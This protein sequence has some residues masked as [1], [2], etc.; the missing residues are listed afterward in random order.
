MEKLSWE[1]AR[2]ITESYFLPFKC[3]V[4]EARSDYKNVVPFVV[5]YDFDNSE[6][7]YGPFELTKFKDPERLELMLSSHKAQFENT[8]KKK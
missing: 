6:E 3:V 4:D 2:D 1:E 5:Y 8:M 7:R